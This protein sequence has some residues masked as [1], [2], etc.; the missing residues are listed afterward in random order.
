MLAVFLGVLIMACARLVLEE[1]FRFEIKI[2]LDFGLVVA[3]VS[4]CPSSAISSASGFDWR[5]VV[6]DPIEK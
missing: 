4:R 6:D 2:S 3:N 5:E 1:L